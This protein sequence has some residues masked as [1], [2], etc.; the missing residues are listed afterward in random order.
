MSLLAVVLA[1]LAT[2]EQARAQAFGFQQRADAASLMILLGV[3]QGIETLPP[4]SGQAFLYQYDPTLDTYVASKRP[5]P[6]SRAKWCVTRICTWS[7]QPISFSVN[8]DSGSQGG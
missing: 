4:S 5:G 6:G 2:G 7:R 3:S 8:S 1:V